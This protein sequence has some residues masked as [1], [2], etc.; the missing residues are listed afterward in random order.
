VQTAHISSALST[1]CAFG[2]GALALVS[3]QR[4]VRRAGASDRARGLRPDVSRTE[5]VQSCDS[6]GAPAARVLHRLG[7]AGR[8]V[9]GLIRIRS[10]RRRDDQLARELPAAVD[11]LA[12]AVSAGAT[13]FGAVEVAARWAPP[14]VGASFATVRAT[15]RLGAPFETALADA[16]RRDPRLAPVTSVLATGIRLGA[17]VNDSLARLAAESRRE[18]RRRAEARAR[19][20]PVRLLF[21]LVFL[22]LPAFGLLTVVPAVAAGFRGL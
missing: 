7:P 4:F 22:V 16:A 5:L 8:V 15:C 18:L 14:A 20:V 19:T 12:V 3:A 6:W 13:P 1:G 2:W 11:L 9:R 21:P 17:A 10:D